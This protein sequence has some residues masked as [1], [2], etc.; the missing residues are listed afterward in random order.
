MKPTI[1]AKDKAHLKELISQDIKANGNECD[2]N[3]IDV[4]EIYDMT[5]LFERSEFNG[6]ISQW[7]VSNLKFMDNMFCQ[8]KF[9]G[10]ISKWNVSSVVSMTGTFAESEFNGDISNWDVSNVRKMFALF[11]E[12]KFNGDTTDWKPFHLQS[13][14]NEYIFTDC[15]APK[16]YWSHAE[17][18]HE[19]INLINKYLLNEQLRKEL[20]NEHVETKKLKI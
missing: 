8:S 20:K 9:N 3:H 4:S 17:N 18:H 1:T 5:Y 11:S 13:I 19:M 10:D 14:K 15:I 2:L 7:N 6:N 12:S 16:P